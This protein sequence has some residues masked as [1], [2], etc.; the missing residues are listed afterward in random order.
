MNIFELK[1]NLGNLYKCD[2]FLFFANETK[3]KNL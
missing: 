1:L 2:V 3:T